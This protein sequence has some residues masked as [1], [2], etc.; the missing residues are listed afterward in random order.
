MTMEIP[1]TR[2][3]ALTG[4][5]GLAKIKRKALR[6]GVWFRL[7]SR[8][9]RAIMDLT[10][11]VVE[12]IR[13]FTLAKV[14]SQIVMKLLD[15]MESKV[16]RLISEVGPALAQKLS[17]TAQKWGNQSAINWIE[18]PGFRQYLAVMYHNTPSVFKT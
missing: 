5:K 16:A 7:L 6:R 4:K 17:I 12:K 14:V 1:L 3:A 15:S 9:E 11:K 13:S 18:D 2:G 10:I 8:A